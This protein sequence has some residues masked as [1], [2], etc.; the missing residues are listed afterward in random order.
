VNLG[1]K[2]TMG[3]GLEL[4][5]LAGIQVSGHGYGP[6]SHIS[7]QHRNKCLGA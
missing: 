3:F 2:V 4:G 1:C 7:F 6:R 5:N